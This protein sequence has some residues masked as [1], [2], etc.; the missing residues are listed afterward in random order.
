M[1]DDI[2]DLELDDEILE[3]PYVG[4]GMPS[5]NPF[6]Y[7]AAGMQ[8]ALGSMAQKAGGDLSQATAYANEQAAKLQS[9]LPHEE[10]PRPQRQRV[11]V[12]IRR[13]KEEIPTLH[14]VAIVGGAVVAGLVVGLLFKRS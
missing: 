8:G 10:E 4:A 12:M 11:R 6:D 5:V 7:L 2:D 14:K 13:V 9:K 1:S 3:T